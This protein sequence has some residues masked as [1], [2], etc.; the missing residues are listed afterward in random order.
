MLCGSA[1]SEKKKER[2]IE[3]KEKKRKEKK[4]KEKKRKRNFFAYSYIEF[5]S[6]KTSHLMYSSFHNVTE[7]HTS[8]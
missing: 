7:I 1:N 5:F 8:K 6:A 4:R 3:R 2:K